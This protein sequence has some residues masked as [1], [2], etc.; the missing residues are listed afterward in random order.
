VFTALVFFGASY[1]EQSGLAG[2]FQSLEYGRA[3]L[4]I[5]IP[6]SWIEPAWK[7]GTIE[8]AEAT[9]EP[10]GGGMWKLAIQPQ[11]V[12]KGVMVEGPIE[13]AGKAI[14]A[15]SP[16]GINTVKIVSFEF[17]SMDGKDSARIQKV[18]ISSD[19]VSISKPMGPVTQYKIIKE[20]FGNNVAMED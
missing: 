4:G 3:V 13:E 8:I 7:E 14:R 19:K 16:K 15:I 20:I 5:K 9:I 12:L 1:A 10:G 2:F 18:Q 6:F 17:R 11:L